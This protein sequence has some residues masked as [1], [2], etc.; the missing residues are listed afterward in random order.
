MT[1]SMQEGRAFNVFAP[2][3]PFRDKEPG[4]AGGRSFLHP[5]EN[6]LKRASNLKKTLTVSK[7]EINSKE[8]Q[9]FTT[10]NALTHSPK[11]EDALDRKTDNCC[12][13]R[14]IVHSYVCPS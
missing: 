7:L 13:D 2:P 9:S 8:F 4:G 11:S 14:Q 5:I 6:G 12:E 10:L 3:A 1:F